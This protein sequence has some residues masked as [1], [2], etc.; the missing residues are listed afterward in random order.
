MREVANSILGEV[1]GC[2]SDFMQPLREENSP[3]STV[4]LLVLVQVITNVFIIDGVF[5]VQ[6]EDRYLV[7]ITADVSTDF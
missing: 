1:G 5:D 3:D 4:H 7:L 2:V 6:K